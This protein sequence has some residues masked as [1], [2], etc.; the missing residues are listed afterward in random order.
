MRT[1][2]H[3]YHWAWCKI[4]LRRAHNDEEF[5]KLQRLEQA[6]AEMRALRERSD[7]SL[8][9]LTERHN[10]NHWS[11]SVHDMITGTTGGYQ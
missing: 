7:R 3:W 10:R 5:F 2:S 11:E 1:A 6:E 9:F 4:R 8:K